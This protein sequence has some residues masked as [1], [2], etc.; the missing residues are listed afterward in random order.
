M[1]G[2]ASAISAVGQGYFAAKGVEAGARSR[3]TSSF[4]AFVVEEVSFYVVG[5]L[6]VPN[7]QGPIFTSAK[8]KFN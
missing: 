3:Q 2:L 8:A 7:R 6:T 5:Y 1:N 4:V